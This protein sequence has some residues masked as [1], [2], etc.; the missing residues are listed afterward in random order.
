M[1][2]HCAL[3]IAEP[4]STRSVNAISCAHTGSA[5][6]HARRYAEYIR[7]TRRQQPRK[8]LPRIWQQVVSHKNI[9]LDQP[10]SAA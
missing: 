6:Y 5:Q 4:L 1:M 2:S 3:S 7:S 10:G 8:D 9:Q